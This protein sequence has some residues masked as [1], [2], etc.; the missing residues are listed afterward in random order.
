MF[1]ASE[2]CE[3]LEAEGAQMA[4]SAAEGLHD[5]DDEPPVEVVD[6]ED[7]LPP[8]PPSLSRMKVRASGFF[9]CL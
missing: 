3:L 6:D 5:D 1:A 4:R 8:P 2:L 9:T 7:A